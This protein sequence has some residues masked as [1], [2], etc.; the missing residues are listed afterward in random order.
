MDSQREVYI[1]LGDDSILSAI[2]GSR[3][4]GFMSVDQ[5]PTSTFRFRFR[6]EKGGHD[7]STGMDF[8][9]WFRGLKDAAEDA[10]AND[11]TQK[12]TVVERIYKNGVYYQHSWSGFLATE[13]NYSPRRCGDGLFQFDL[14][15]ASF[16][17]ATVKKEV[18]RQPGRWEEKRRADEFQRGWDEAGKDE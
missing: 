15:V 2:R 7:D 11:T 13:N 14:K 6:M 10:K 18:M 17:R 4:P 16:T 9:W 3:D 12:A 8:D 1:C 5:K